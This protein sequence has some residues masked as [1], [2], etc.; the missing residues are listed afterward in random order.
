M[1]KLTLLFYL[2]CVTTSVSTVTSFNL[3]YLFMTRHEV[4][5][6]SVV[7]CYLV[8]WLNILSITWPMMR[9]QRGLVFNIA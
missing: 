4:I 6:P 2:N 1:K 9:V 3:I 5:V 8:H 7:Q